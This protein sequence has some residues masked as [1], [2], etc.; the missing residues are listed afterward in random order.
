V[1]KKVKLIAVKVLDCI[2][3]GQYSSVLGGIEWTINQVR[4]TKRPSI[5]NLSL[6]GPFSKIINDAV[7]ELIKNGIHVAVAAGNE[8]QDSCN[9]SP[10]NVKQVITVASLSKGN[11]RSSFSNFGKCVDIYGPG[12]IIYSTLPNGRYGYKS[13]TSMA[14]PGIVGVIA[15][16]LSQNKTVNPLEMNNLL[17]ES[18]TQNLVLFNKK[19]TPNLIAF[20]L[21]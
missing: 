13:G 10:S 11:I 6:G 9:T 16:K 3:G 5:V 17:L 7:L 2:G 15:L 8:D 19:D 20:N 1:A 12:D 21:F 14:S 4:S 18:A